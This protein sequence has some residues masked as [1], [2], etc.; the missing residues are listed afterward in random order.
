MP[1][2]MINLTAAELAPLT[3]PLGE[4]LVELEAPVIVAHLLRTRAPALPLGAGGP[5][6][7]SWGTP[8][9]AWELPRTARELLRS[10]VPQIAE[11]ERE[12]LV[13]RLLASSQ[14]N[15]DF[16]AL[17]CLSTLIA[18]LGLVRDSAS[19][20]IGAML[21]APLMTPLVGT[22]LALVQGNLVLIRCTSRSVLLG[23]CLVFGIGFLLGVLLPSQMT[24][25][26]LSRGSPNV[27]DLA[28]AFIIG[29]A[30]AYASARP[31]LSS[32]LP[33]VAIAAALVPPI[34]TSGIAL[35]IGQPL[36]A[37]GAVLLFVATCVAVVLGV[38]CCMWAMG[39]QSEL[40]SGFSER[41][42]RRGVYGLVVAG[43]IL[44][45]PLSYLLYQSLPTGAVP[46]AI[47]EAIDARVR[48]HPGSEPLTV[49]RANRNEPVELEVVIS[50]PAPP[51]RTLARDLATIAV[52]H[53][54][55]QVRVRVVTHIVSRANAELDS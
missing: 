8:W 5:P 25:E 14:W 55:Q 6:S 12:P 29:M 4:G 13:D 16:V 27:I 26:M 34:A 39:I 35:A 52:E 1:V 17:V 31:K 51:P 46:E 20:V 47:V 50:S 38:S 32:V 41:W 22:G 36:I 11:H 30:A 48:L 18:S 49:E 7:P 42:V 2:R 9:P 45:I 43:T 40:V 28:A 19:I 37:A 44:T 3:W 10:T 15:F 33:G 23:F 54:G 24:P 53:Y 21:V